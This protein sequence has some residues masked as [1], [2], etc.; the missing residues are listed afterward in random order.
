MPKG[1]SNKIKLNE[2]E[3]IHLYL[4]EKL[5][6]LDIAKKFGVNFGTIKLRLTQNNIPIRTQS[7]AKKICM[8]KSDVKKRVSEGNK[9][10]SKQRMATNIKKYGV[11]VASNNPEKKK[12]WEQDYFEKHGVEWNK[13]PKRTEKIKKTSLERYGVDNVSKTDAIREKIR[14][15]RWENKTKDEL[16]EIRNK[17]LDAFYN[18]NHKDRVNNILNFL[19]LELLEPYVNGYTSYNYKCKI[20]K[21]TF[22]MRFNSIQLSNCPFCNPRHPNRVSKGEKEIIQFLKNEGIVNIVN[23][24]KHII[25]PYEIDI[26]LPDYNIAIE[27]DG[28][29]YHCD[30]GPNSDT[31]TEKYHLL[32]TE[33]CMQQNIRLIHLFEDEWIFKKDIVKNRLKYFLK[34]SNHD[35]IYAR[36]CIIKEIDIQTKNKFL[37]SFHIQGHD[38]SN[39]KLGAYYNDILVS[40]MT[41]SKGS[42]AKGS[43]L[44]KGVWELNRFCSDSNYNV[45]GIVSKL[46]KYFQRNYEWKEIFTYADRR[47]SSGHLYYKIGFQLNGTSRPNYWY[48]K[49]LERH[50]RFKFRKTPHEPKNIPEWAL[51]QKEGYYRIW[52]CGNYKFSMNNNKPI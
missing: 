43:K 46:L 33:L 31:I 7:Q 42:I 14:K 9:K 22:K 47:W 11:A 2:N 51:R 10:S 29:W 20:C 28:L 24:S 48:V 40:V 15:N 50:H 30:G 23:N 17:S 13:D 41:F 1:G 8:N 35:K 37:N 45:I 21:N 19:N 36:K 52:D 12:Q 27:Y 26:Y 49:N 16:D 25:A 4:K 3:I 6:I 18:N 5:S 44:E 38:S 39:I 32:K 34:L